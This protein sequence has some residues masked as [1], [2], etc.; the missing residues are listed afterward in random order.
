MFCLFVINE[1]AWLLGRAGCWEGPFSPPDSLD[2][3]PTVPSSQTTSLAAGTLTA[4]TALQDLICPPTPCWEGAL[5]QL[6]QPWVT[7]PSFDLWVTSAQ[8]YTS[9]G[10][11]VT[12]GGFSNSANFVS[13]GISQLADFPQLNIILHPPFRPVP[14]HPLQRR[15]RR[16]L[17][18]HTRQPSLLTFRL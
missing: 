14:S 18:E 1:K 7:G 12:M 5:N 16:G 4:H 3:L 2:G 13:Q 11:W 17:G 6:D 10:L 8:E 15:E 9:L